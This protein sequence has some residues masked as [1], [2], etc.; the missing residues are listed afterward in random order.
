MKRFAVAVIG[1]ALAISACGGESS[2]GSNPLAVIA[3]A[4]DKTQEAGTARMS[5]EMVM[6]GPTGRINSSA[7]GVLDMASKQV[8]MTMEMEMP[9]APAGTPDM[10]TIEGVMDGTVMYMKMPALSAQLPSGKPWVS[11]DFQKIGEEMGMDMGALM[12]AGG[13]DPTQAMQYLRGASGEV[14]TLGEEEVRGFATTHYRATIV[15]DK[16]VEQAPGDLRDRLEPTVDLIKEWAGTDEM[17][18][19]VWI[20]DQ[21]RMIR[22]KQS[23]EYAA[24]PAAGMSMDMTLEMYDFGVQVDIEPPPPSQVTDL[25]DLM[26]QMP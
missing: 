1:T 6:D 5:M 21:G 11:F 9:D 7:E 25:H 18:V 2:S 26:K 8:E 4:A 14:K 3:L 24:G 23:F 16:I 12:Q 10:G 20:D 22:Q 15:F 17:P 19:E 13:S